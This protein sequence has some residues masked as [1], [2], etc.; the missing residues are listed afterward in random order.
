M[1]DINWSVLLVEGDVEGLWNGLY[2]LVSRHPAARPLRFATDGAAVASEVEIN[3]DLTQELFLELFQKQRF[4]HYLSNDYTS[5]EIEN[6]LAH[7]ELSNLVGARLR[8]RYPES[9]RMARR[10]STLLKTSP[11]FRKFYEGDRVKSEVDAGRQPSRKPARRG[12]PPK[13]A[14]PTAPQNGHA[15]LADAPDDIGEVVEAF[16]D[17]DAGGSDSRDNQPRHRRMVKT[18]FGLREWPASKPMRDAGHFADTV[19]SVPMRR[20]DTRVVGRS[21]SSQLILSNPELEELLVEVL[22]AIDSPA[23]VR[24][25]RQLALSRIPLQDYNVASLDEELRLGGSGQTI[26]RDAADTRETPEAAVLRR[27]KHEMAARLAGEFL[28]S[29]RRAVN[30]NQRRYER[31]VATLWHC[32]F[33][34]QGP[35]QLEIARLLGVSDSLVSDNRRLIEV[36]LR[37]LNLSVEE[38]AIFSESLQRLLAETAPVAQSA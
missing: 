29:L 28:D 31:L 4:D 19:Q 3:A 27:E 35:S 11:R 25:L 17:E 14:T 22:A 20:R 33:D 8:K 34:P 36:E 16:A 23:D 7:I 1:T 15:Q 21:G 5:A 24:T 6:E 9:F 10:V 12:R 18:I 2:Q 26:R 13:K 32:Y 38:G 30:H 37:K